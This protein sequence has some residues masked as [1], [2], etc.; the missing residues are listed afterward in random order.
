MFSCR[1]ALPAS[2]CGRVDTPARR[3]AEG[4]PPP[5]RARLSGPVRPTPWRLMS[6]RELVRWAKSR[7]SCA[8]WGPLH[9]FSSPILILKTMGEDGEVSVRDKRGCL[10]RHEIARLDQRGRAE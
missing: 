3:G 9:C 2:A 1:T 7:A 5:R 6:C 4:L 10:D 8:C